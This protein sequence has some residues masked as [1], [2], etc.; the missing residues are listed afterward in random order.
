MLHHAGLAYARYPPEG[1]VAADITQHPCTLH[2]RARGGSGQD[3]SAVYRGLPI[4]R[5]LGGHARV[6]SSSWFVI[7][8]ATGC[9]MTPVQDPYQT[10]GQA[11]Q[12]ASPESLAPDKLAQ[13]SE[14][15]REPSSIEYIGC[16]RC[17][18]WLVYTCTDGVDRRAVEHCWRRGSM[19]AA[20][21]PLYPCAS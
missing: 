2:V 10:L 6:S 13:A 14:E 11:G 5:M 20:H 3:E 9:S 18:R 17:T 12:A 21:K 19:L 8:S 1:V 7:P 15:K 16:L 4:Q